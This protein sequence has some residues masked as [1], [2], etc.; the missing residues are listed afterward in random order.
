MFLFDAVVIFVSIITYLSYQQGMYTLVAVFVGA[1]VIDF[2]Q[3]GAYAAKGATIISEK[4][5]EIAEKILSKMDRGATFLHGMGTYTK[6][7]R[8]VLYCVVARNELI[9]LKSIITSIDPHA[10]VAVNDVH[11][12]IGEGFTL[13]ENKNP[14]HN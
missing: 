12:V 11:D 2:M 3:E 7:E 4:N 8:H 10:F 9:K 13:D 1:R 14:L 5:A 6:K